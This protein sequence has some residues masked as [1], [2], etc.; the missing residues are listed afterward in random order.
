MTPKTLK[1]VLNEVEDFRQ[2]KGKRH[3]LE[4]I[5]LMTI[6]AIMSG[7]KS[8]SAIAEWGRNY[9]KEIAL[10]LRFKEGKMP[11]VGTLNWVFRN[12]N[13]ESLERVL[14]EYFYSYVEEVRTWQTRPLDA[15]YPIV[16]LD[17]IQGEAVF[18]KTQIQL[19]IIHV[20]RNSL[21]Y[22]S[23]KDLKKLF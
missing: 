17:A 7:Y 18:P 14:E 23:Y 11:C 3:K 9:G 1:E 6:A 2:A 12:I 4:A 5:L 15:V 19:C 22:V 21:A 16:Y 8:Y 13:I 20:I 10:A